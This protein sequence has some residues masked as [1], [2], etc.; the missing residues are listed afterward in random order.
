MEPDGWA[1][2]T[3]V[4]W[5]RRGMQIR[6]TA[7]IHTVRHTA[8][9]WRQSMPYR[10]TLGV[11]AAALLPSTESAAQTAQRFSIQLSALGVQ[12]TGGKAAEGATVVTRLGLAI[13]LG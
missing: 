4:A 6:R 3:R 2:Q 1:V 10:V 7:P 12:L 11:L 9:F 5:R 13:G 8:E